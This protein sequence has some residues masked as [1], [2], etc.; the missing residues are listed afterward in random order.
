MWRRVLLI[1]IC[2]CACFL[3]ARAELETAVLG[4]LEEI[5]FAKLSQRDLNPLGEKALAIHP[6]QWKHAEGEH[7]IYHFVHGFVATPL[8]VEAE[9]YYRV[10]A[11]A[12]NR[13][14]PLGETKSHIYVFETPEDWA[15]F[16]QLGN[17][18]QWTGGIHSGGSLFVVRDPRFKFADNSLGHEIAHLI[19]HRYYSEGVPSWIDEGFAEYVSKAAHASF[20]RARGYRAKPQSQSITPNELI[21]LPTLL[22]LLRPPN[23]GVETFYAESER[24]VRFLIATDKPSFITLL[25]SLGK[26]QPFETAFLRSFAGKFS[27]TASFEQRFR[28]YA[29]KDAAAADNDQS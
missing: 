15:H 9:F 25:D 8:S 12:L 1:A 17:L 10:T 16:Q 20:R 14:Q 5:D 19:V 18:E 24:L 29:S 22:A 11:A 27:T 28:D 4:G 21:P 3:S 2:W 23:D 26:H 7:F 6:E 13:E